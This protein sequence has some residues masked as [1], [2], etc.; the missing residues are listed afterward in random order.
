MVG[1]G[2]KRA[3]DE[4]VQDERLRLIAIRD[5]QFILWKRD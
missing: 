5:G 3:V 2:V 1:G 4:F